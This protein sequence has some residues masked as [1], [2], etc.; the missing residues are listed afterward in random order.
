MRPTRVT[1]SY[2]TVILLSGALALCLPHGC[3]KARED[4]G[5]AMLFHNFIVEQHQRVDQAE[6][7]FQQAVRD[8]LEQKDHAPAALVKAFKAYKRTVID[9]N[10]EATERKR[11]GDKASERFFQAY[12]KYLEQRLRVVE[13]QK[14]MVDVLTSDK[15]AAEEISKQVSTLMDEAR[16]LSEAAAKTLRDEQRRYTDHHDLKLEGKGR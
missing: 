15:L 5:Q 16:K 1:A 9:V 14:A 2:P 11:P 7:K 10:A 4:S 3:K 12:R 13:K 8:V 6:E